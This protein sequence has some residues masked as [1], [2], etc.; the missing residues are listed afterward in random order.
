MRLIKLELNEKTL[1]RLVVF[2][3]VLSILGSF[4]LNAATATQLGRSLTT[5]AWMWLSDLSSDLIMSGVMMI[6][7]R[8][9]M[10]GMR[11]EAAPPT[12]TYFIEA[13]EYP[14]KASLPTPHPTSAPIPSLNER[15]AE[16][17]SSPTPEGRQLILDALRRDGLSLRGAALVDVDLQYASL[18]G[19]DLQNANLSK[20]KLRNANLKNAYL[21]GANLF[22]TQLIEANLS[23]A[24]LSGASLERTYLSG[25]NLEGANLSDARVQTSLWGVNLQN[26]DLRGADLRGVELFRANLRGANLAGAEL[27]DAKINTE[28]ILPDG[29]HWTRSVDITRFTNPAHPHFWSPASGA[30]PDPKAAESS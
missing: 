9:M 16:L 11:R 25:A 23:G 7:M 2:S 15:L 18:P 6:F 22:M 10:R 28:T 21:R 14:V 3:I 19:C 20:A 13:T 1:W 17:K 4:V 29:S 30:L 12:E 27:A 26:A 24:D 8:F 5:W